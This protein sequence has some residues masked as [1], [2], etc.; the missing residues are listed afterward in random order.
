MQGDVLA[1][2]LRRLVVVR[3]AQYDRF[4]GV[5]G[6]DDGAPPAQA[7]PAPAPA[8]PVRALKSSASFERTGGGASAEAAV[9]PLP[10]APSQPGPQQQPP[11]AGPQALPAPPP[12][13]QPAPAKG[14]FSIYDALRGQGGDSKALV[15]AATSRLQQLSSMTVPPGRWVCLGR[16]GRLV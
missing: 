12:P 1:G 10:A 16:G 5:R 3:A 14:S 13:S 2:F 9:A 7:A 8:P 11:A 6:P 15:R 4:A